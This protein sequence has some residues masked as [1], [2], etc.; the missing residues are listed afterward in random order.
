MTYL[1]FWLLVNI[2]VHGWFFSTAALIVSSKKGEPYLKTKK[3]VKAKKLQYGTGQE[4]FYTPEFCFNKSVNLKLVPAQTLTTMNKIESMERG[5]IWEDKW[6]RHWG[7][8][9][10]VEKM[11]LCGC[12]DYKG[13]DCLKSEY[14]KRNWLISFGQAEF[15]IHLFYWLLRWAESQSELSDSSQ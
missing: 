3:I 12:F 8:E 15:L 1:K 6:C 10:I 11:Q 2:S 14:C 5:K 9:R 4:L 13:V 7:D